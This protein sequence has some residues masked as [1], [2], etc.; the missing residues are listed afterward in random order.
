MVRGAGWRELYPRLRWREKNVLDIP[1]Y[2]PDGGVEKVP[3]R[4][5]FSSASMPSPGFCFRS[6]KRWWSQLVSSADCGVA[7]PAPRLHAAW[8]TVTD[9][10]AVPN[11]IGR[12]A[13]KATIVGTS[14][15]SPAL[16]EADGSRSPIPTHFPKGLANPCSS[17]SIPD[18]RAGQDL[19][20]CWTRSQPHSLGAK[21]APHQ[22]RR[23]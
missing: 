18:R 12:Y 6:I 20:G 10:L 8:L 2:R 21:P 13:Q 23:E 16:P 3:Q 7:S 9:T 5:G 15:P 17:R 1:L 14:G 19:Y 11:G 22:W 4:N